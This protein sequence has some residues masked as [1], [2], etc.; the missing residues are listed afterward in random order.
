MPGKT[1][2]SLRAKTLKNVETSNLSTSDK[3][4]IKQVFNGFEEAKHKDPETY[5]KRFVIAIDTIL[6]IIGMILLIKFINL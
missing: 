5:A 6:I 3:E 4:C 1:R 2:P